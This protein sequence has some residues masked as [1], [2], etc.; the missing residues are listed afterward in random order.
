MSTC[1]KQI[2]DM[3]RAC[4]TWACWETGYRCLNALLCWEMKYQGGGIHL[5]GSGEVWEDTTSSAQP[6]ASLHS[7]ERP[8]PC[9]LFCQN[10]NVEF[11]H[12]LIMGSVPPCFILGAA[13]VQFLATLLRSF[14]LPLHIAHPIFFI[15]SIQWYKLGGICISSPASLPT[16]LQTSPLISC[17]LWLYYFSI[18]SV[19]PTASK[20]T[21]QFVLYQSEIRSHPTAIPLWFG[22]AQKHLAPG[23]WVEFIPFSSNW[24]LCLLM[25]W[26]LWGVTPVALLQLLM[27]RCPHHKNANKANAFAG[28][29]SRGRVQW[30]VR[31]FLTQGNA[32]REAQACWSA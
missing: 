32:H 1:G 15:C 21:F 3:H 19:C 22:G 6:P 23:Y 7:T 14:G 27:D 28:S 18:F 30:T 31:L 20:S 8:Q 11:C 9:N 10:D 17:Q 29:L 16:C 2:P 25:G 13:R 5:R 12:R 4:Q 26:Q 24:K